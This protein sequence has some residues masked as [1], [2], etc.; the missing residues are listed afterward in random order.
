MILKRNFVVLLC[1]LPLRDLS[2][3]STVAVSGGFSQSIFYCSQTKREYYHLFQPYDT[4]LVNLSYKKDLSRLQKNLQLGGQLEF[5]Q[6]S[7]WFYYR[8]EFPADTFATG[9]RYDI[10]SLNLYI[11]PELR[12]GEHIKFVFSGGP[13]IQWITNTKAE[14][15]QIQIFTGKPNIETSISEQSSER[16]SGLVIGAKINLGIEIP[17]YKNL[18]FTFYNAYSAGFNSMQGT[19]KPQM[20]Y[21]NC[22]DIN[23]M[24][25]LLYRIGGN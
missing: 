7:A 17:L 8:D 13:V 5:K 1:F 9:L 11:F 15:T 4:Y 24:G 23:I 25:G 19:I 3:Q 16:I 12:V 20:K 6:Q 10:Q 2:A 14:G 21:F 22:L 18:Y